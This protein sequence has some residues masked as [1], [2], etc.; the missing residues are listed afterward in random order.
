MGAANNDT[1]GQIRSF[2][3]FYTDLLGLLNRH[4]L[5]S[6][7]SLTEVRILFEIDKIQKCTANTLMNRLNIDRGYMSRILKNFEANELI[8]K[9]ISSADGRK[10]FLSLTQTG[11]DLLAGLEGKSDR[12]VQ[13]LIGHL[14]E[15]E[16][17][18]LVR[19]MQF[20]KN[21]LSAEIHPVSIRPYRQGD[22]PYII[23]RHRELY[24]SEYGFSREFGDYVEK[25]VQKFDEKHDSER[26]TIWVAENGDRLIG[27]I[28]IV[29]AD[30]ATA[31][32]RWFLIEPEARGRGLGRR[33]MKTVIDFCLEKDYKHVFLWTVNILAAARHLY[34]S[35]GFELTET[36]TN[37][38]W[39]K[40]LIEE[41]WDL[42]L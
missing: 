10:V 13:E 39:G 19:S 11:K 41:R 34:G 6:Q 20:I 29:K 21:T 14:A 36:K 37:D 1:I 33:L 7:Y 30:D 26:E 38:S 12:Q 5:D 27:A 23:K 22:L 4:I 18:E 3:R 40:N 32:L 28:A 15:S 31:Q 35:Y 24:E 25:Y 8:R 9:E 2:S 16:R 17:E 42:Q